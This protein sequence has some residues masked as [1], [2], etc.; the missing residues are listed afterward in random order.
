MFLP[1]IQSKL[2]ALFVII[3]FLWLVTVQWAAPSVPSSFSYPFSKH[4]PT[5]SHSDHKVAPSAKAPL[6]V[7]TTA[8][9][10]EKE[11]SKPQASPAAVKSTEPT[12]K[13]SKPKPSQTHKVPLLV[14]S[15][16]TPDPTGPGKE[17]VSPKA[18]SIPEKEK[19]STNILTDTFKPPTLE[20][21]IGFWKVF[22]KLLDANNPDCDPPSRLGTAETIGYDKLV[23][24]EHPQERPD[25]LS[26]P[27]ASVAMMKK[28]HENFV[29]GLHGGKMKMVYTPGTRGL[30][31]TA[32]GP[33]LPVFVIS[34]RMLRRT[35][36]KLPM[37]V[38]LADKN[39]YEPYICD[40]VF[41]KLDAKC[42]V[43]SEI[44]EGVPH[45]R[46]ITHYQYKVFAMIFSSFEE[47]LFLDSDAFT[48]H[49]ADELFTSEPFTNHGLVSWPDFWAST[50]SPIY[51][52][53]S[54]Q[55]IPPMSL[56]QSTESGELLLNKKTHSKSLLLATYY[57]YYNIHYYPLFSQ[58]APGEGDKE[59]FLAAANALNETFYAT[60]EGVS[61]IGHFKAD[62][63]FTGS[64]M[65][66]YDPIQDYNLT[67]QGIWRIMNASAAA[68]PRPFFLHVNFPRLNPT[69]VFDKHEE[70]TR[71]K[72]GKEQRIWQSEDDIKKRFGKDIEKEV[73]EEVKYVSCELEDKFETFQGERGLCDKAT[74]HYQG[75]FGK[76]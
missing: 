29:A 11:A 55:P 9:S 72:Q 22:E 15:K 44:L 45:S 10:E 36:T 27:D 34:L 67:Q 3:G 41:P 6:A 38:F 46:D 40:E 25:K 64:A 35:G 4:N 69:T 24:S 62:K 43:L 48:L 20:N 21:R 73:W 49:D 7:P 30:V 61:P 13:A 51:Y 18:T 56:R 32:G 66:Q 39:E 26:M 19:P 2:L 59:T 76:P 52:K 14:V 54:S 5:S 1:R 60:S 50:A 58:G 42:V 71:D 47:V 75:V 33:Y 17:P 28:A 57:N 63:K 68:Q 74:K 70:H 53:I 31:T 65:V 16:I 23:V 12:Q 37:E 8:F